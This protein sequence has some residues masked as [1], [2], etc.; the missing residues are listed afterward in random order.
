[1]FEALG[2]PA[3]RTACLHHGRRGV[4]MGQGSKERTEGKQCH[5][6]RTSKVCWQH[7][8]PPPAPPTCTLQTPSRYAEA[9]TTPHPP[10][11]AYSSKL[12][13][14]APVWARLGGSGQRL[15]DSGCTAA[16]SARS[17]S[18]V[19][20]R[21][22]NSLGFRKAGTG[23]S[24]VPGRAQYQGEPTPPQGHEALGTNELL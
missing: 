18:L 23:L 2:I 21:P 17:P 24:P 13:F 5:R 11:P 7:S 6:K 20:R 16:P 3:G 10:F 12:W 8:P 22:K 14:S 1:M 4:A 9:K 19:A 15:C